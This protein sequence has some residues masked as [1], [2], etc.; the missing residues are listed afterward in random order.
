MR[1][2]GELVYTEFQFLYPGLNE[3]KVSL[4]DAT[5]GIYKVKLRVGEEEEVLVIQKAGDEL[6]K[7]VNMAST[8]KIGRH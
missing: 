2:Q 3:L 4:E 7:K 5:E 1:Y 8:K 6:A